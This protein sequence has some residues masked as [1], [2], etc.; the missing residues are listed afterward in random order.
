[1]SNLMTNLM[2]VILIAIDTHYL[3]NFNIELL[4]SN[5]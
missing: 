4:M 5:K 3:A 1:M 2:S